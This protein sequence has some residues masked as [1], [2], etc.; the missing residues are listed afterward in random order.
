MKMNFSL[1]TFH[2]PIQSNPLVFKPVSDVGIHIA[3]LRA[4]SIDFFEPQDLDT[5]HCSQPLC[6][7]Y[8]DGIAVSNKEVELWLTHHQGKAQPWLPP[9]FLWQLW[10]PPRRHLLLG[11]LRPFRLH[12]TLGLCEAGFFLLLPFVDQTG[13]ELMWA[14][15]SV[16]TTSAVLL[17]NYQWWM[18]IEGNVEF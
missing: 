17:M 10:H 9:S 14:Q 3:S 5:T 18:G 1:N 15:M 16:A 4:S 2:F 12:Y 13:S 7:H 8:H 11:G 6:P